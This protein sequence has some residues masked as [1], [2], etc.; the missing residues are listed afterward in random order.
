MILTKRRTTVR[1]FLVALVCLVVGGAL[2]GLGYWQG[3]RSMQQKLDALAAQKTPSAREINLA[4]FSPGQPMPPSSSTARPGTS[5]PMRPMMPP[6]LPPNATPEMKE[7]YQNRATLM[8]KMAELRQKNG[9]NTNGAPDP[10]TID[11]FKQ[12]NTALLQ[13]QS[14]LRQTI[15]QQPGNPIPEPPLAQIP[16]NVSPE[17]RAY[18]TARD[19][20]TRDQIAFINLHRSDDPATRQ[21]A[22]QQ[23]QQQNAARIQQLQQQAQTL[24]QNTPSQPAQTAPTTPISTTK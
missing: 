20:L 14:E 13:R 16:A 22:M 18:L 6:A 11:Q 23:W 1:I 12:E 2:F 3:Q 10:K 8:E 15:A 9:D 4:R 19:Q 5:Q 17:M 21:A 24:A 7:F